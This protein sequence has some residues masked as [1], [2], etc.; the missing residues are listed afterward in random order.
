MPIRRRSKTPTTSQDAC[1]ADYRCSDGVQLNPYANVRYALSN[2]RYSNHAS[3]AGQ[4]ERQRADESDPD[5]RQPGRLCVAPDGVNVAAEGCAREDK[6]S[7]DYEASENEYRVLDPQETVL[8]E[9][10]NS[11]ISEVIWAKGF[12]W[13]SDAPPEIVSAVVLK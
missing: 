1:P 9:A 7:E 6:P 2:A 4:A 5:A 13:L 12:R 3:E 10:G 8:S 11:I